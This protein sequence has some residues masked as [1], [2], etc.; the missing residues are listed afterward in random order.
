MFYGPDNF[1]EDGSRE[2]RRQKALRYAHDLKERKRRAALA[3]EAQRVQEARMRLAAPLEARNGPLTMRVV[4]EAVADVTG[5]TIHEIVSQRR[6]S[7]LVEA[8]HAFFDLARTLTSKSYPQIGAFCGGRDHST[9]W[10]GI[11]KVSRHR[12]HY[13]P[14]IDAAMVRLGGK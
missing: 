7:A 14:I 1:R 9:V 11:Q 3:L 6:Q 12:A 13:Q 4:L 5:Y 8:R 10:H 2:N